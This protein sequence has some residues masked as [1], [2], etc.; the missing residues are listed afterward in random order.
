LLHQSLIADAHRPKFGPV[1]YPSYLGFIEADGALRPG[2]E[3]FN[4]L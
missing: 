3:V 4:E 2:H 1:G